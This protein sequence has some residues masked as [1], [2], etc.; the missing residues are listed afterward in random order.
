MCRSSTEGEVGQREPHEQVVDHVA[1]EAREDALG[2]GD[3]E[4]QEV[5]DAA[6]VAPAHDVALRDVGE[7]AGME[8]D[9]GVGVD[10]VADREVGTG[11]QRGD[12]RLDPLGR[13]REIGSM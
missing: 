12:E 5:V 4:P 8:R 3:P 9:Q 2:V 13:E 11:L 10:A 6:A 1:A 7:V